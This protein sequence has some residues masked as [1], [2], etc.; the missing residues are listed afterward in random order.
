MRRINW[1]RDY[2]LI[3]D[4]V[5]ICCIHIKGVSVVADICK[6]GVNEGEVPV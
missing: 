1:L 4:H 5:S 3:V 6:F 2:I